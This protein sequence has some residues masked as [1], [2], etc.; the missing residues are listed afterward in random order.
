MK[1]RYSTH[2]NTF[3]VW[4]ADPVDHSWLQSSPLWDYVLKCT[5]RRSQFYCL[6]YGYINK[7]YITNHNYIE[8]IIAQH[9]SIYINIL[10]NFQKK[11]CEASISELHSFRVS[12]INGDEFY[13]FIQQK[14][15][16]SLKIQSQHWLA[17]TL[18]L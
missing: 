12:L 1:Q 13:L 5:Y 3:L 7:Y 16:W 6:S 4:K 8:S 2:Q 10:S 9:K 17:A 14:F 11:I 15:N 18:N